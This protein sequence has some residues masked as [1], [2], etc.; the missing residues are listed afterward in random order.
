LTA[1]LLDNVAAERAKRA[2]IEAEKE[3]KR[4]ARAVRRAEREA[5]AAKKAAE[6]AAATVEAP[7]LYSDPDG[8]RD[9][10]I[11]QEQ[12]EAI[13]KQSDTWKIEL[14]EQEQVAVDRW[15]SLGYKDIR[16]NISTGNVTDKT[17][18]DFLSALE[19]APRTNEVSWRGIRDFLPGYFPTDEDMGEA[20]REK[21]QKAVGTEIL[22][23][24]PSSA[25]ISPDVGRAFSAGP[26]GILFEIQS[27]RGRYINAL[28]RFRG[29]FPEPG[30]SG[31]EF[32]VVMPAFT[33][34]RVVE[35]KKVKVYNFLFDREDERFLVILD[36]ITE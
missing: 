28:N 2:V 8:I 9:F 23:E 10:Q 35:T 32:E 3:V 26:N 13:E 18:R 1:Q 20:V 33:R 11:T 31:D 34:L 17:T 15:S 7:K 29:E 36:D 16:Y 5:A 4:E 25:S 24:A 6:Q 30:A 19:K 27:N 22:W 21:W 14:S 12:L